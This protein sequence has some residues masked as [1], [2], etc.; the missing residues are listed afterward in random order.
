MRLIVVAAV[1]IVAGCAG[2]KAPSGDPLEVIK[3][4][5]AHVN[6]R[7]QAVEVAWQ[8]ARD[9]TSSPDAVRAE[10][11]DLLWDVSQP[12]QVRVAAYHALVSDDSAES[13][14][15]MQRFTALRLP[16]EPRADLV[17]AMCDAAA[18]HGWVGITSSIVRSYSRPLE[19]VDDEDRV[20]RHALESLHPDVSVERVTFDVF[21]EPPGDRRRQCRRPASACAR[22]R[23]ESPGEARSEGHRP[24]VLDR[25]RRRGCRRRRR[26][27]VCA[28]V[29][30][31]AHH[32]PGVALARPDRRDSRRCRR[33]VASGSGG[34]RGHP[35]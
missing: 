2:S 28:R 16:T 31:R 15:D 12:A 11:K 35:R 13:L 18:T 20:E 19:K 9:G 4:P 3:D 30:H 24:A 33:V 27:L 5:E 17:A 29:A 7:S 34:R 1:L 23:L 32:R 21:V 25:R 22:R 6:E 14:A 10:F 26:S 8:E